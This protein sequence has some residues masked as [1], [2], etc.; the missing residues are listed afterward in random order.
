MLSPNP[1]KNLL[2]FRHRSL[3]LSA[4]QS[5]TSAEEA[6]LAVEEYKSSQQC[7]PVSPAR[8]S[9]AESQGFSAS[10]V[11]GDEEEDEDS[12]G[13]ENECSNED[14][15]YTELLG[16]LDLE[17][18]TFNTAG[19]SKYEPFEP[20]STGKTIWDMAGLLFILY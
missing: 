6:T 9:V 7:D 13:Y 2:D 19:H 18:I 11:E 14:E 20:D 4:R 15:D 10:Q 5:M 3:D 12:A 8:F 1:N 17:A 16:D